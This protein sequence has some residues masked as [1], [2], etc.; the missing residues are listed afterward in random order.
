[1]TALEG[2]GWALIDHPCC[3]CVCFSYDEAAKKGHWRRRN[4]ARA[5]PQ[6]GNEGLGPK[7][8]VPAVLQTIRPPSLAAYVADISANA[9]PTTHPTMPRAVTGPSMSLVFSCCVQTAIFGVRL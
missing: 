4:R 2:Y 3:R 5:D 8:A 9:N 6:T 7:R 1:M